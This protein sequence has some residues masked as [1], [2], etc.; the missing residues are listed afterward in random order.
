MISLRDIISLTKTT[1]DLETTSK[2]PSSDQITYRVKTPSS[3]NRLALGLIKQFFLATS[4]IYLI[5]SKAI[6]DAVITSFYLEGLREY[7]RKLG[8]NRK[9]YLF[10]APHLKP[11][12]D[13]TAKKFDIEILDLNQNL[14]KTIQLIESQEFESLILE[15]AF[16]T[17]RPMVKKTGRSVI[18]YDLLGPSVGLYRTDP[19][20]NNRFSI[21]LADLLGIAENQI[22]KVYPRL[23][24]SQDSHKT[25][26]DLSKKFEINYKKLQISVIVEASVVEKR[27]SLTKW[28]KVLESIYQKAPQVE[29]NIFYND[30]PEKGS[31]KKQELQQAFDNLP[32]HLISGSILDQT[33]LL[34]RQ[35]LVLSND[36]GFA[37]I[38]A[39]L[40]NGPKVISLHLPQFPP[41][42]WVTNPDRHIGFVAKEKID[43]I[44]YQEIADKSLEFLQLKVQN[45]N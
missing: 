2:P 3:S 18:V 35:N 16:H 39:I 17:G 30:D 20:G 22:I 44:P 32:Y 4:P 8:V 42:I 36:T 24:L 29:F 13:E 5:F 37:H 11:L 33:L 45:G 28:R 1:V 12:F 14:E 10:L 21:F 9:I 7:S 31:Y 38:A 27:Y 23:D 25:I 40:Q 43:Q 34:L 19:F 15:V 26:L 41:E 6:G